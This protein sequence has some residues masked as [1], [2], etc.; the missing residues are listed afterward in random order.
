MKPRQEMCVFMLCLM[1]ILLLITPFTAAAQAT[2][3]NQSAVTGEWE[4][5]LSRYHLNLKIEQAAGGGLTGKLTVADQNGATIPVDKITMTP[6]KV[7]RLELA[8]GALVIEG[9]LNDSGTEINGTWQES[10]NSAPLILRRPGAAATASTLKPRTIGKVAFQPCRTADGNTEGLCGKY[11]VY[12]NRQAQSGRKIALNILVLPAVSDKPAPDPFFALAGG[13][14]QSAVEAFPA[15]GFVVKMRQNHDVVLVDQRGTGASNPLPCELRDPKDA[16]SVIG[17]YVP[18]EKVRSCRAELEKNAD[19]AQYTTSIFADDLDEVRQAMGYGKINI[20]GGSYGSRAA[21]VYLRQ[22]EDQ[23]RTV[24][25]E[26]IVPPEYRLMLEF[27]HTI[28]SSITQVMDRCAADDACHKDYPDLKKEFQE[29]IDRLAKEPAHFEVK[30]P[31]GENQAIILSRGVFLANLRPLLYIPVLVSQFPYIVHR[32]YQGDWTTYGTLALALRTTIDKDLD[33]GLSI[34]VICAEDVPG[35]TDSAIQRATRGTWLGDY[36][37]RMY[38]KACKEWPQGT[39]PRNFH[40]RMHSAVPA[41]LIS[42]AL[43]PATPASESV[44]LAHDL[45]NSRRVVVKEGTHGTGSPC[46]DGLISQFVD[47]GSGA[48]LDTSCADAI[49][50]PPFLTQAQLDKLRQQA[51]KKP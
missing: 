16:Q 27:P 50:L 24:T 14:G 46:I 17:E 30:T 49:H 28:Q 44:Q 39:V 40:S 23:V 25:L 20:F 2:D 37:T 3:A 43:D 35:V 42:G 47:Q 51:A 48:Q 6:E 33:R 45:S 13:P 36:Q 12:E 31:R 11:E 9:K 34:S 32:A 5:M 26:G 41:L 4:G 1:T 19:L 10:G 15:A 18:L 8:Q 29:V 38:Q 7:V 21:L 22:H